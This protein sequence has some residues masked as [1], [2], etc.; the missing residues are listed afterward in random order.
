MTDNTSVRNGTAMEAGNSI[1]DEVPA[2]FV[3]RKASGK[4]H[5]GKTRFH[6]VAPDKTVGTKRKA[7]E[8]Q[9][10][11]YAEEGPNTSKR[12]LLGL[13]FISTALKVGPDQYF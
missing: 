2:L 9:S 10:P 5:K 7:D 6:Q 8:I 3:A 11:P 1:R 4:G 13:G 12:Q